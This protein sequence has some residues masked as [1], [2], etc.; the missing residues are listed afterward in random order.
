MDKIKCTV[1][2]L[3]EYYQGS[4]DS[5]R[6][7]VHCYLHGFDFNHCVGIV[8]F[9]TGCVEIYSKNYLRPQ[10]ETNQIER[11][12]LTKVPVEDIRIYEWED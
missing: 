12:Q 3:Y 8:E 5:S 10:L 6:E 11:G 9:P 2:G 1:N 7:S 4:V